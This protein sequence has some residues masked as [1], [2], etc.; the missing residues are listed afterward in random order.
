MSRYLP[1]SFQAVLP[2]NSQLQ[3]Q[4]DIE[5]YPQATDNKPKKKIKQKRTTHDHFRAPRRPVVLAHGIN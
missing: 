5:T 3:T 2:K 1:L 4:T